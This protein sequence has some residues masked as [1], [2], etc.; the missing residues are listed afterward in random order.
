MSYK[1]NHVNERDVIVENEGG[2][3][4]KLSVFKT[5][6]DAN[7][8][9]L[10]FIDVFSTHERDY[11][12]EFVNLSTSKL[13]IEIFVELYPVIR[14]MYKYPEDIHLK[15]A[16]TEMLRNAVLTGMIKP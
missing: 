14:K 7:N 9:S 16:V 5:D 15:I 11:L 3:T 6:D 4:I 1:I 10:T 2:D 12:A 13:L 8:M